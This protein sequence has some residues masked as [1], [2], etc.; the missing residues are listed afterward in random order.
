[1]RWLQGC[2][3]AV[4]GFALM[5]CGVK[6]PKLAMHTSSESKPNRPGAV[7]ASAGAAAK[8]QHKP[9]DK[10]KYHGWT[11]EQWA[12]ALEGPQRET[13]VRAC[14]ALHILGAEGRPYLYRGL[15]SD[16]PETR[17]LCLESLSVSDLRSFGEE[18]KQ[19]LIKL[20]GDRADIRIRERASLYI[21]QWS[22]ALPA[23]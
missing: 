19:M 1:M 17:R 12:K 2:V 4:L 18:G 15:E 7:D 3:V 13:I 20:A 6:G 16:N 11:A 14:Q 21:S 5:G 22:Q 8:P 10:S 23:P 9:R